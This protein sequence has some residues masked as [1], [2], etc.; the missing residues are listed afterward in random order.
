M[1][2][3]EKVEVTPAITVSQGIEMH[4]VSKSFGSQQALR[5]IDLTVEA[6][7]FLTVFGPNGSGKTTLIRILA[8]LTKPSSGQVIVGGFDLKEQAGRVRSILGVVTHQ[9]LLYEDLTAY[10]NL[11][12]YG[13]MYGVPNL[14]ERIRTTVE[15]VGLSHRLHDRVR[16][17]SHGMQKRLAIARAILHN[18]SV[19]LLDEPESGL[20]QEALGRFQEIMEALIWQKRTIVM[21]THNLERGLALGDRVVVLMEGKV[22]FQAKRDALDADAFSQTYARLTGTKQ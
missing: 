21:T 6:G 8:T 16:T 11:T 20:D 19:L 10:E 15:Q 13:R 14:K 9:P 3:T 4:G 7:K 5:G 18:P 12:F 2:G 22:A 1:S 17:L